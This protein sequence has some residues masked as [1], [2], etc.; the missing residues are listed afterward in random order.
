M[1]ASGKGEKLRCKMG[2]PPPVVPT[3]LVGQ[4]TRQGCQG[5]SGGP[6][7]HPH[8]AHASSLSL[9]T[10]IMPLPTSALHCL[11]DRVLS[12]TPAVAT[13]SGPAQ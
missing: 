13:G 9:L 3:H 12:S 10:F 8:D 2:L 6:T 4:C 5:T 11:R 7:L 1:T